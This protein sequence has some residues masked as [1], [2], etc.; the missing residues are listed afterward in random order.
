MNDIPGGSPRLAC[1]C[2]SQSLR[3]SLLRSRLGALMPEET[4]LAARARRKRGD[5]V[6]ALSLTLPGT[7]TGVTQAVSAGGPLRV[8]V[9]NNGL[10][11]AHSGFVAAEIVVFALRSSSVFV[12]ES[13]PLDNDFSFVF[14]RRARR[15]E[16]L[17]PDR[18]VRSQLSSPSQFPESLIDTSVV[19]APSRSVGR[20]YTPMPPVALR[21]SID[22]DV[23]TPAVPT[24]SA[25]PSGIWSW[26][27]V[28]RSFDVMQ[29][30][31]V[32]ITLP[33]PL[34][35]PHHIKLACLHDCVG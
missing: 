30:P 4:R 11:T 7:F 10:S 25:S 6:A 28:L 2:L 5:L 22:V 14:W 27:L 19:G 26:C 24:G 20:S 31:R 15:G 9:T 3:S 13:R 8:T 23:A 29:D 18:V 34:Q 1:P 12:W 32:N 17:G 35:P 21:E 33:T 16:L